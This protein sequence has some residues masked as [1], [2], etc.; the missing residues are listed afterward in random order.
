MARGDTGG[1][2]RFTEGDGGASD[3]R[4]AVI[5]SRFN[6]AVTARL[7]E[8]ALD[9]LARSRAADEG[10]EV[11]RVPGAWE[12]PIAAQALAATGR[13]DAIVA[14]GCVVR[15]GTPHFEYVCAE[16][17][18]GLT[19][20][21]LD[22]RIPVGLGVLTCD[23]MEQALDRAGGKDGNKG[24]EAALSAIEMANLLRRVGRKDAG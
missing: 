19:R 12:I 4:V 5:V 18:R 6:E 24:A 10:V 23:T 8:G 11:V 22:H 15:G 16:A 17:M 9:A 14:L 20:V 7:L 21:S 3:L 1:G 13:F 2:P